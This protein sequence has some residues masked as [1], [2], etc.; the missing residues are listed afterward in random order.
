MVNEAAILAARR[1]KKL[2]EM[3]EFQEAVERVIAGPERRSRV[4]SDEE[5]E[6]VAYHEA[7]HTLAAAKT[8]EADKVRK[9]TIIARGM[10]GGYTMMLPEEDHYLASRAK[11]EA[12]LVTMLGGRA[13]EEVVFERVTTGASND[14]ER[15][16]D[17]ARKMVMEYGMSD[18]LG[19]MVFGEREE[20]IF[21]GRQI[22][23]HRNYSEAVAR[24]IDAEVRDI[25][26]R[27]HGR[28]RELMAQ[29]RETLDNLARQ[30]IQKETL[31]EAEVDALLA[32]TLS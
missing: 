21:L 14:L 31:S 10:A 15:A 29:Y 3:E 6:V 23:E 12:D 30:L 32:G 18:H 4:I 5:K 19:P 11:F 27:A 9:V 13:A 1:N 17:L 24:K 26:H 28:A 22:A 7:G 2:I 20:L 8:P 16:T 25:I